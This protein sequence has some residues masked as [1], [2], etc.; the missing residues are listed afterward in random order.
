M[1]SKV[2]FSVNGEKIKLNFKPEST[3]WLKDIFVEVYEQY[4]Y[5]YREGHNNP[6]YFETPN[7]NSVAEHTSF[8]FETEIECIQTLC[9]YYFPKMSEDGPVVFEGIH[10]YS[11]DE[12][13]YTYDKTMFPNAILVNL[14]EINVISHKYSRDL[15]EDKI[16]KCLPPIK[17][18]WSNH[19]TFTYDIRDGF[20][21]TKYSKA[22]GYTK[23]PAIIS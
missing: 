16:Y 6:F 5:Y 8:S 21:R 14:D 13:S 11:S 9:K 3:I 1:E 12:D 2:Y 18:K 22:K 15:D 23:I 10:V 17:L 19:S 20:H 7:Q 4:K